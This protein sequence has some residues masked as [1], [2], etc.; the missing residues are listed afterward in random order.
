[1]SNIKSFLDQGVY[2]PADHPVLS[3]Q[4]TPNILHV[5]RTLPSLSPKPY[6]FILV[7][8]P[9]QFKPEYWTRVVA[10]FT[11]GQTWQFRGYK[12]REPQALFENVLGLY[13]G[14]KGLPVPNDIKGWGSAV[15]KF[16]LERWDER[17]HG[18]N[19]DQ[20]A[21]Q[22]RRWRDRETVE[23]LWRMLEAHMRGKGDWKR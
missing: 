2:V 20:E 9:D 10:V 8:S 21:R 22:N 11:T 19:V 5:T 7:E 15:K 4:M 13:I 23:E 16:D 3:S 17:G 6:R 1:M 14:E 18:A 12:W